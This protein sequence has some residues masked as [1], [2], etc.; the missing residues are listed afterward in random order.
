MRSWSAEQR[1]PDRQFRLQIAIEGLEN[2]GNK[3][4]AQIQN[5]LRSVN[6]G[7]LSSGTQG[8]G[9]RNLAQELYGDTHLPYKMW[10]LAMKLNKLVDDGFAKLRDILERIESREMALRR[11]VNPFSPTG[12]GG[13]KPPEAALKE[14]NWDV[15]VGTP[16]AKSLDKVSLRI[17]KMDGMVGGFI[18][19][20][21]GVFQKGADVF[22]AAFAVPVQRGPGNRPEEMRVGGV[23]LAVTG[24]LQMAGNY[25]MI[26][27]PSGAATS[28]TAAM[29]AATDNLKGSAEAL[30]TEATRGERATKTSHD[31]FHSF[32]SRITGLPKD[33]FSGWR[34][35]ATGMTGGM[36]DFTKGGTKG[37]GGVAAPVAG[38]ML[39][40][41][42]LEKIAD[43]LMGLAPIQAL[44]KI[45]TTILQ[46]TFL[47]LAM[48]L[49]AILMPFL[50]PLLQLLGG[51]PWQQIFAVTQQIGADVHTGLVYIWNAI[52]DV[53]AFLL[54][55]NHDV[56]AVIEAG[57]QTV[58]LVARIISDIVT[59][60][61]D[62]LSTIYNWFTAVLGAGVEVISRVISTLYSWFVGAFW[63][64]V[65]VIQTVAKG[66][67]D[68]L[69]TIWNWFNSI[70]GPVFTVIGE[71][72]QDIVNA[73]NAL[74]NF[75]T[76]GAKAASN[77]GSSVVNGLKSLGSMLGLATGGAVIQ[78][79]VAFIHAGE[80]VLPQG[81]VGIKGAV[82]PIPTTQPQQMG[83][84]I[85]VNVT[86]NNI[87]KDTDTNSLARS[88]ARE[89][90][91]QRRR[92]NTW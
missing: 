21:I 1:M 11:V 31:V 88:I 75:F 60:V 63:A 13:A 47:P 27:P 78:E 91:N 56:D 52:K 84:N 2:L 18:R 58:V 67:W 37:A 19:D 12:A 81:A 69:S 29:I 86:G 24:Q 51:L 83:D 7:L 6:V 73:I 92:V 72:I 16:V 15:A 80:T 90:S 33:I 70:M 38:A 4:S 14:I 50:M 62:V 9:R 17:E 49:F 79:G 28:G 46:L 42:I 55:L 44:L 57:V 25:P 64:G 23:P 43:I 68:V 53:A 36:I 71:G 65:T 48:V 10:Q 74:V 40:V 87:T 89:M 45:M 39:G 22:K 59:S 77:I 41:G 61:W 20:I 3:I 54:A 85:T 35:L 8:G 34:N 30:K 76:G 66:I 5:A 82:Q 32:L 26:L